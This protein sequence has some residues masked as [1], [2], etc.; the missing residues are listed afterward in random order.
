MVII[1]KIGGSCL[2]N[3]SELKDLLIH[4]TT[5][6]D[7]VLIVFS[8]PYGVTDLLHQ[9]IKG[10]EDKD[11]ILLDIKGIYNEFLAKLQSKSFHQLFDELVEVINGL[12]LID[13]ISGSI[14]D[15][16]LSFGERLIIPVIEA[17]LADLKI[18]VTSVFAES[19]I[20]TNSTYYEA[21]IDF[22]RTSKNISTFE[23]IFNEAN[24][25]I[26]PGYYGLGIDN[27]IRLLGRSG[28]DYTATSLAK[29]LK[30][31]EIIFW[32]D[33]FGIMSADPKLV[34]NAKEISHLSFRE[35]DVMTKFGTQIL[36]SKSLE[37]II[38]TSCKITIKSSRNYKQSTII[39]SEIINQPGFSSVTISGSNK[40]NILAKNNRLIAGIGR[41][42]LSIPKFYHEFLN[43]CQIYKIKTYHLHH[44]ICVFQTEESD[45]KSIINRFHD[46]FL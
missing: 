25:I 33:V 8:A 19:I 41:N 17:I 24:V 7:K 38:N 15:K 46:T 43:F 20:A 22:K 2:K 1:H 6:E 39:S 28:S 40:I 4:I 9:L 45:I 36:H 23:N 16:I 21:K 35:I 5:S 31:S 37:P 26:F 42:I 30:S 34:T 44:N 13:S 12:S 27:N 3:L 11:R 14:I 29:L 32:K 18:Q 10:I